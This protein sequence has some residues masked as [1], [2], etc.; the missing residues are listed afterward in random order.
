MRLVR[1][2]RGAT[3]ASTTS[4]RFIKAAEKTVNATPFGQRMGKTYG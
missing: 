1:R 3:Q 4:E 2:H